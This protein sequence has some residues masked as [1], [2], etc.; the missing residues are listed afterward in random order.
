MREEEML[1]RR[2]ASRRYQTG[3]RLLLAHLYPVWRRVS[4]TVGQL[5]LR[6][7]AF[8]VILQAT[9]ECDA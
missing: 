9:G 1:Q 6:A 4:L 2:M 7:F 8:P 3:L 5:V